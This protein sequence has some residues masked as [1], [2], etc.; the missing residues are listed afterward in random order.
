MSEYG[1]VASTLSTSLLPRLTR[2]VSACWGDTMN[3][4]AKV[5]NAKQATAPARQPKASFITSLSPL[6]QKADKPH[7][8][9]KAEAR[10]RKPYCRCSLENTKA[11]KRK[12]TGQAR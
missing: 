12:K 9:Q 6:D 3:G 11:R 8:V 7:T 10:Q 5:E 1:L 4:A 2:F